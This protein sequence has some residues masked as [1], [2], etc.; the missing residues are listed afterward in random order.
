MVFYAQKRSVSP[1]GNTSN[2][3]IA[4]LA[5]TPIRADL[6][7]G[8][9]FHPASGSVRLLH[10]GLLH[11]GISPQDCYYTHAVLHGGVAY[12]KKALLVAAKAR[13]K[14]LIKEL[15]ECGAKWIVPMGR[16]ALK[17]LLSL[18]K[19]P[20]LMKGWRGSITAI[21]ADRYVCPVLHPSFCYSTP[22]WMPW[23]ER[24]IDRIGR[25]VKAGTWAPPEASATITIGTSVERIRGWLRDNAHHGSAASDVETVGL[26]PTRTGLVCYGIGVPKGAIIIPWSTS[27]NGAEPYWKPKERTAIVEAVNGYFATRYA[28][29]HNGPA[30][31]HIVLQRYGFV[32]T[33]WH[34]T[35]Y[36]SHAHAAH[37]P[38]NLAHFATTWLDVP[39][40]KHADHASS[41]EQLWFYNAQDVIYTIEGFHAMVAELGFPK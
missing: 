3:S 34:D 15:D 36:C 2:A 13:K 27:S 5:D 38:K 30:F 16:I 35:L 1:S 28:V 24:D 10:R 32:T 22:K 19:N 8:T 14:E 23:F 26:G 39:P 29:S 18:K 31:D 41:I 11:N 20:D 25:L 12:D 7:H 21:G 33:L 17:M 9:A 40:W 6:E 4:F 37:M